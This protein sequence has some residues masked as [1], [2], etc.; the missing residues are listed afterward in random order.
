M[1]WN[2][3]VLSSNPTGKTFFF[4]SSYSCG[5][6]LHKY[7]VQMYYYKLVHCGAVAM[8]RALH[9]QGIFV[10]KVQKN[11]GKATRPCVIIVHPL[12]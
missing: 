8:M 6:Y 7:K 1:I 11:D 9:A 10:W 5:G 12:L 2:R 4:F 3:E